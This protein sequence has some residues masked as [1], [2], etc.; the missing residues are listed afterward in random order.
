MLYP[1]LDMYAVEH[2]EKDR[3]TEDWTSVLNKIKKT[4]ERQGKVILLMHDRAFRKGGKDASGNVVPHSRSQADQ[5]HALIVHLQQMR[6][7]FKG[8]S[9]FNY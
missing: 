1:D 2:I 6:V 8:L 5:L 7:S 4:G 9:E 3:I